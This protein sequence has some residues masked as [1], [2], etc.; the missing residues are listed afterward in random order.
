MQN[1]QHFG[2]VKLFSFWHQLHF[3]IQ[4]FGANF[5]HPSCKGVADV[6]QIRQ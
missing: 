5:G 2:V 6:L 3:I 1:D 4:Q